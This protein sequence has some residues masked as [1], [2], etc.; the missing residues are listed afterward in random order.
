[1]LEGKSSWVARI[2][3][4]ASRVRA[5][6]KSQDEPAERTLARAKPRI[7]DAS[8]GGTKANGCGAPDD[9]GD[10]VVRGTATSFGS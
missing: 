10:E 4:D 1:V 5:G 9:L 7:A 6:G 2:G 8:A 3:L